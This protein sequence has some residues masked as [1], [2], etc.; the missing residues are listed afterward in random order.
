METLSKP[1]GIW[2]GFLGL[3]LELKLNLINVFIKAIVEAS[4]TN[5][6]VMREHTEKGLK[7]W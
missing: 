1:L 6:I 7:G 3:I 2:E 4:S 5:A